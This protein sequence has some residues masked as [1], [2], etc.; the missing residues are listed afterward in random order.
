[1]SGNATIRAVFETVTTGTSHTLTINRN[2]ASI[3][4]VTGAGSHPAG[5][6]VSITA[7]APSGYVF[8]GWTVTSTPASAATFANANNA[9]TT[10]TLSGNATIVA[11][12]AQTFTLTVNRDPAAGGT[13]TPATQQTVRAN[14]PIDITATPAD[15]YTF[16][17]W[18]V[19]TAASTATIASP[20]S[21]STTVTLTANATIRANFTQNIVSPTTHTLTVSAGTGGAVTPSGQQEVAANT[22]FNITAAAASGYT[23]NNWTV[24]TGGSA[25]TFANANSAATTVTLSGN[26]AIRANFTQDPVDPNDGSFLEFVINIM[27]PG[28]GRVDVTPNKQL[29]LQ[30]EVISLTAVPSA[31]FE[32]DRWAGD[33]LHGSNPQTSTNVW[34]HRSVQVHFRAVT[35]G[36]GIPDTT[37][38]GS[39]SGPAGRTDT[40]K[41]EAE[42]FVRRSGDNIQIGDIPG[43]GQCIGWIQNG[44][45]TTYEVN[46]ARAGAHTMQFRVSNGQTAAASRFGVSVNGTNAGTMTVATTGD[47]DTYQIVTFGPDVQLVQGMNTIVLNFETAINV[48][49]FLLLGGPTASV[50]NAARASASRLML[51]PGNRGFTA[52]LPS[53]HT[54]TSYRLIDPRGRVVKKGTV[55][56]GVTNL[57]FDNINTGVLFLRLEG[58]N[59]TSTVVRVV[60]N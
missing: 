32:F 57:R 35:G 54:Y 43:G 44:N 55:G 29:F 22:P 59:N 48:D 39:G 33:D 26:A 19:T 20:G 49:Y 60:T 51:K 13:V 17:G 40:T 6:A 4:T 25:A 53:N 8:T 37:G 31:G 34:W 41:V 1:L 15:G 10:V 12:F 52:T 50:V 2:P 5:T 11:N 30:G 45:S 9:S 28:S 36:G 58:R 23:F 18:T 21:A 56:D 47:W 3:G 46:I 7:T 27:P 14:T 16:S 24:V 42:D 38:G